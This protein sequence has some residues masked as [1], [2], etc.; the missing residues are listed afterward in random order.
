MGDGRRRH[1]HAQG[2]TARVLAD[3]VLIAAAFGACA[4]AGR[5]PVPAGPIGT[6]VEIARGGYGEFVQP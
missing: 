5:S 1:R 3:V 4:Q 6:T 2:G